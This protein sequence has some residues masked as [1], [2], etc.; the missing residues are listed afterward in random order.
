MSDKH[1]KRRSIQDLVRIDP[2]IGIVLLLLYAVLGTI[3]FL[4]PPSDEKLRTMLFAVQIFLMGAFIWPFA[5]IWRVIKK[6]DK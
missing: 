2:A 4:Y 6:E 1:T 5:P 3:T